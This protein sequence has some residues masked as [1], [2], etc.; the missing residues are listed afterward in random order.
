MTTTAPK[1]KATKKLRTFVIDRETWLRGDW[2]H[3]KLLRPDGLMCCLGQVALQLG[4][5]K[6]DIRDVSAPIGVGRPLDWNPA[7]AALSQ[8]M[9]DNDMAGVVDSTR[10]R[11]LN[12][13]AKRIGWRL[14]FV[15]PRKEAT[16]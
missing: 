8:M 3:S 2:Q 4:A 14:K 5:T 7:S 15:G 1:R 6:K 12:K 9:Q 11:R 13:S 10:E 16:K